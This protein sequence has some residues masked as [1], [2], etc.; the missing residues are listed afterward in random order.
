M[1]PTRYGKGTPD[2]L[3]SFM[4]RSSSFGKLNELLKRMDPRHGR[5][6]SS[7]DGGNQFPR[8]SVPQNGEGVL[9]EQGI[10][11][12]ITTTVIPT[13]T[14]FSPTRVQAG[15]TLGQPLGSN[16]YVPSNAPLSS[17]LSDE[18]TDFVSVPTGEV[19]DPTGIG[20]AS[21]SLGGDSNIEFAPAPLLDLTEDRE[22]L[23]GPRKS[24]EPVK[25]TRSS[26]QGRP[27]GTT[28]K[29]KVDSGLTKF[30]AAKTT[31]TSATGAAKAATLA[32]E[33]AQGGKAKAAPP[34]VTG[35]PKTVSLVTT[36][37]GTVTTSAMSSGTIPQTSAVT[38]ATATVTLPVST[39]VI[40]T[41][42]MTDV[43]AGPRC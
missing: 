22:E 8:D 34:P 2:H 20:G 11:I 30:K 23:R 28:V 32:K 43:T 15:G 21:L 14:I 26:T 6:D 39:P 41:S 18:F 1:G 17:N 35:N 31:T 24:P 19:S 36:T 29:S 40:T 3:N 4:F 25:T 7:R 42:V 37:T 13:A 9:P 38:G 5:E 12:T 10:P 33:V 27:K 16:V